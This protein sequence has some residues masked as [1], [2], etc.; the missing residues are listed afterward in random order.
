MCGTDARLCEYLTFD[1]KVLCSYLNELDD[2]KHEINGCL[3]CI[4]RMTHLLIAQIQ[5]LVELNT[6]VRERTERPLLLE[7]GGEG[8]VGNFGVGLQTSRKIHQ[9]FV[10]PP[11]QITRAASGHGFTHHLALSVGACA[12][13]LGLA[14]SGRSEFQI[15]EGGWSARSVVGMELYSWPPRAATRK[16]NLGA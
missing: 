15:D 3:R 2:F 13:R 10:L 6:T 16:V 7:L 12:E 5:E 9:H 1:S 8:G 14:C 4:R 11:S